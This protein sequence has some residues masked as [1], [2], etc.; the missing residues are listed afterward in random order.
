MRQRDTGGGFKSSWRITVRQ[1]ESM[2]RLSEA[3]ARL[4]CS[5]QVLPK[6]VKEAYRLLNKSIIRVDQPDIHF[7]EEDEAA[8]M[9]VDD[10]NQD[11]AAAAQTPDASSIAPSTQTT[12]RQLKLTYEDYRTMANVIVHYLKQNENSDIKKKDVVNWYI[13]ETLSGDS[14]SMVRLKVRLFLNLIISITALIQDEIVEKKLIVEKVL[15]RLAYQDNVLV[16]LSKTGLKAAGEE[17]A[18]DDNPILIVH[19]NYVEDE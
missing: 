7:D 19:P 18:A 5:D 12:T 17:E 14:E 3:M 6:H 13:E 8:E 9:D 16:P 1:L 10:A 11:E 15:D 2:V 4:G